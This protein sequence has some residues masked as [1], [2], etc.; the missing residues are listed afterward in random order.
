MKDRNERETKTGGGMSDSETRTGAAGAESIEREMGDIASRVLFENDRVR[1][2][3]LRMAAGETGPVHQ[4]ALDHVLI[5]IA[6]D[7]VAVLPEP[8]TG[9]VYDEYLEADIS[10][11]DVLFVRR[12]GI[13]RARN[14]GQNPYHEI[15]VELKD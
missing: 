4:H 11:G 10:P 7:R 14:V 2:W 1:I 13:E 3:E 9:S 12:G 15:I 6:G 8:D 5:Q